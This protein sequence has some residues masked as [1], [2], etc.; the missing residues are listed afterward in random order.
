MTL[1]TACASNSVKIIGAAPSSLKEISGD[2]DVVNFDK[3]RPIR[4]DYDGNRFAYFNIKNGHIS[5]RMACNH[6]GISVSMNPSAR[7]VRDPNGLGSRTTAMGCRNQDREKDFFT[8]MNDSP[9]VEVLTDDRLR[10]TTTKHELIVE[11]SEVRRLANA[12][13]SVD[14]IAG[15]WNVA[16]VQ[17]GGRGGFGG[18]TYAPKKVSISGEDLTIVYGDCAPYTGGINITS[19]ALL[20][21]V[22]IEPLFPEGQEPCKNSTEAE[23]IVLQIFNIEPEI[24]WTLTGD[25][26]FKRGNNTVLLTKDDVW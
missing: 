6:S 22:P 5:Y 17:I 20:L 1:A 8:M 2:W 10:L 4:L 7:L 9:L 15:D 13:H 26:R 18:S 24:E 16:M 23:I 3:F 19:E 25:L 12:P 21:G 11:R 14:E